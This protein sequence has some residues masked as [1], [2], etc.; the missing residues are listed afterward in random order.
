MRSAL[1]IGDR[2][3]INNQINSTPQIIERNSI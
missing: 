2:G 1:G 3:T